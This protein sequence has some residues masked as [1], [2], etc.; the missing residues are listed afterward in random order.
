MTKDYA[1]HWILGIVCASIWF[2]GKLVSIP[3]EAVQLAASVV[4]GILAHALAFTPDSSSPNVPAPTP[5]TGA[6]TTT[7]SQPL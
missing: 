3:P 5:T 7:T 1:V 4:P 2:W 6:N